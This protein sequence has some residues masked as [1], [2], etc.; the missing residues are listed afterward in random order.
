MSS[1]SA[2]PTAAAA[3]AAPATAPATAP[4]A[5]SCSEKTIVFPKN[6][7]AT[8]WW[9]TMNFALF[10]TK[11]K[12]L[13]TYFGLKNA[14]SFDT[15]FKKLYDYYSGTSK[16]ISDNITDFTENLRKADG[17]A[18][19]FN[20]EGFVIDSSEKQ[21][22]T[23]Y[24]K[25]LLET[26]NIRSHNI[27]ISSMPSLYDIY[28]NT[29][30]TGIEREPGKNG[31]S[32][33]E[34]VQ[35]NRDTNTLVIECNRGSEGESQNTTSLDILQTIAIPL[36]NTTDPIHEVPNKTGK[37]EVILGKF[38][39]DAIIVRPGWAHFEAYAKC[40]ATSEWVF[41]GA[42]SEGSSTVNYASFD[43]MMKAKES[44]IKQGAVLLFYTRIIEKSS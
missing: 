42:I 40:S 7:A 36:G 37:L 38:E 6:N 10:H 8:C 31:T 18:T 39:L 4:A 43:D 41:N 27:Q 34:Y 28:M 24:S 3:P 2:A 25:T 5:H 30:F 17:M 22:V 14:K 11:R 23:Q 29:G 32:V 35:F 13:D 1:P 16:D 20:K 19:K 15:N 9:L 12:E 26:F 44:E 21:D 33:K